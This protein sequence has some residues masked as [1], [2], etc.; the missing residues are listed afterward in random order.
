MTIDERRVE[1]GHR[2][3]IQGPK[4]ERSNH[5]L[6]THRSRMDRHQADAAE[7]AARRKRALCPAGEGTQPL[8]CQPNAAL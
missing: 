7:H 6:S 8:R 2:I 4:S 5:A 1:T 3:V